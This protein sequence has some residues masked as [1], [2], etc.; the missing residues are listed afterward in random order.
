MHAFNCAVKVPTVCYKWTAFLQWNDWFYETLSKSVISPEIQFYIWGRMLL[1]HIIAPVSLFSCLQ[2][3]NYMWMNS[4]HKNLKIRLT[5]SQ[6]C[7]SVKPYLIWKS[8]F[9]FENFFMKICVVGEHFVNLCRCCMHQPPSLQHLFKELLVPQGIQHTHQNFDNVV[10]LCTWKLKLINQIYKWLWRSHYCKMFRSNEISDMAYVCSV[11]W[12]IR[13]RTI[14]QRG[15]L[16]HFLKNWGYT[17][18][19]LISENKMLSTI[20]CHSMIRCGAQFIFSSV[21]LMEEAR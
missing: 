16:V 8:G 17:S 7:N 5:A 2:Q 6:V 19:L 13:Y 9:I 14:I 18:Y 1:F 12:W 4:C 20:N 21:L 15:T 3:V 10:L 11:G